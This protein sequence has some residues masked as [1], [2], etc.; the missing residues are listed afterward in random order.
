M[1]LPQSELLYT[2]EEY[3]AFERQS[4]ERHEY[5]DGLIYAMAGESEEHGDISINLVSELRNQL[6]G[7]ECRPWSKD[8]K[9]R[10]GPAPENVRSRKGLF[11][12]PDVLVVCGERKYHDQ[13]KD[14][15]IN[16]TVIIEVLSPSTEAFDRGEKF[17]RYQ[18][19]LPSLK[20]YVLVSQNKPLIEHFSR[21]SD[22]QWI[23]SAESNLAGEV[24]LKS[25]DC[26][27]K[28][29]EIHDRI[30]FPPEDQP[31]PEARKKKKPA[32]RAG[33]KRKR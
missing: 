25:I 19:W 18:T 10:S 1:S 6:K 16:P 11:S 33:A 2:I 26:R 15:L 12:Y 22:E 3:L 30:T 8:I 9:V 23:Y 28:L 27:L 20:D 24:H 5:L 7:R 32:A 17:L 31:K 29:T 13:H 21:R 4:E 14:V